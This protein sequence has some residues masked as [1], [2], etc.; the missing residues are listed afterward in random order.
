VGQASNHFRFADVSEDGVHWALR[1]NC[2][3]APVQLALTLSLVCAV[4]LVIAL[5][6]WFQGAV[7]VLPFAALEW[8]AVGMAF[9]VHAR[10]VTDGERISLLGGQL[11][12]EIEIAGHTQRCEFARHGVRI[13]APVGSALIE[14]CGGGHSVRVGRYLRSDLRPL[15]M[16][17]IRQALRAT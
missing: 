5:F 12:V 9:L 7:F 13:E 14:V 8:V 17:E 3:V 4:S 6:F 16:R 11:V 15:L 2:S 1:R 10:H